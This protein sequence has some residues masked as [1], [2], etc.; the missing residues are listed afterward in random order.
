MKISALIGSRNRYAI[1]KKCLQSV[2]S[3]AYRDFE[4]LLLDDASEDPESYEEL[5]TELNDARVRLIRNEKPLGVSGGRN[6]LMQQAKGAILFVIDDDAYIVHKNSFSII[7]EIFEEKRD[8]GIVACKIQN[9]GAVES[10]L[11]PF[12]KR[13]LR[14]NP[15]IV[16]K[17]QYVGY[18]L[19]T[20][21]AIR[22]DVIDTCGNYD[23]N[24][25]WGCEELDLSYKAVSIGWKIWYEPSILIHHLPQPSVVGKRG[26]YDEIY[27]QVKNRFYLAW[28]Y[29]P[30]KY[31]LPYLGIWM[32][33]H[34]WDAT[35]HNFL[36][37]Y[38]RGVMAGLCSLKKVPR[39]PLNRNALQYLKENWGRLW[40]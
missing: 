33:K 12:K 1:V 32:G 39:N 22:K 6:M 3:Q 26:E 35:K 4:V 23:A 11:V 27:H 15:T 30:W 10:Y 38:I 24:L 29:L 2:L 13:V 37:A 8:V 36:G 9:Y 34:F 31:V 20:A 28:R 7:A 25:F 5:V 18:F 21:H 17:G 40:Y 16:D 19:G 14:K